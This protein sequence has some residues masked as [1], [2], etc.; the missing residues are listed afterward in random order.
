[1]EG[2]GQ[3]QDPVALPGDKNPEYPLN[4]TMQG[5]GN[6]TACYG[7]REN[8][9]QKRGTLSGFRTQYNPKASRSNPHIK[10]YRKLDTL[11]VTVYL[12]IMR[13]VVACYRCHPNIRR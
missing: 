10:T 8:Y 7:P 13:H 2:S 9:C 3:L 1:M 6:T 4:R 5:K 12:V 11:L